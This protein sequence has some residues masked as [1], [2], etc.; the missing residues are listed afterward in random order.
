M[1]DK[2]RVITSLTTAALISI[3]SFLGFTYSRI[4]EQKFINFT[5]STDIRVIKNDINSIKLMIGDKNA[6]K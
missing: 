3:A 4:N 1:I 2:P 5:M 6:F